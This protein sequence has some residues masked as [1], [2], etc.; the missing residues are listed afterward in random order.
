MKLLVTGGA[1][2]IG[3]NF[4]RYILAQHPEDSILNLDKLTY[5]GNLKTLRDLENDAR[6]TFVR[7]DICDRKKVQG[8]I[9]A[10]GFDAIVHFAAETHV[11]RSILDGSAFV[12]TNVLGT[13]CLLD[14]AREAGIRRFV[15]VSTDEVY[16][17]AP[18][19]EKFSE[20][21]PLAPNSPYAASKAGADLLARAH[22]R[23]FRFPV[24]ITRCTN[25]YGP[26]QYPEK[27]IPLMLTRALK[28]ESIPVYGDGMQVRDWIWVKDHCAGLDAVLRKGREGEIY[29][30]GAGNE[31][32]NLE[33]ARRILSLV[34]KP[35]SLLTFVQDRPGHDRR[36]ALDTEKANREL[37]WSPQTTLEEGLKQTVDWY[38]ANSGWVRHVAARGYRAY[39]RKHYDRRDATLA[40]VL[41]QG[42]KS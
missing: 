40:K 36:Y 7:G 31:W 34:G 33:I 17:S 21:S 9:S 41:D 26:Y 25:N 38:S 39:Y 19:G 14:A 23:T 35:E 6:Y 28:G 32:P 20:E 10:G 18:S 13:Q 11:D 4:I 16:G 12:K 42:G 37:S 8:I 1:G 22:F 24:I 30:L 27:F 15:L 5:S 3:S 29:N 2:F